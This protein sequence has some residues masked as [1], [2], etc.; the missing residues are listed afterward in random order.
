MPREDPN[1]IISVKFVISQQKTTASGDL[2]LRCKI[3]RIRPSTYRIRSIVHIEECY[4]ESSGIESDSGL[5]G[6]PSWTVPG[7]ILPWTDDPRG[8][9]HER[10]HSTEITTLPA[11]Q[12]L[13]MVAVYP[14][15]R[16]VVS[17]RQCI[18]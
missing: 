7:G 13:F 18:H 17:A 5:E 14:E 11:F 9:R 16:R 1:S 12:N 4:R 2:R 8:C 10:K 3:L 15:R 6:L